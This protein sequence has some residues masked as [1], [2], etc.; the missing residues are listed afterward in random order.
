MRL[1]V[2]S[3]QRAQGLV[4]YALALSL[5]ALIVVIVLVAVGASYT[6]LYSN[7]ANGMARAS[8]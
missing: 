5:V 4:E 1:A 2:W 7:I 3:S 6:N 8:R